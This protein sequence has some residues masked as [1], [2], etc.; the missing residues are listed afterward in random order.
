MNPS[1]EELDLKTPW[2]LGRARGLK[3][4]DIPLV[5]QI[6]GRATVFDGPGEKVPGV[7]RGMSKRDASGEMESEK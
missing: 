7:G 2:K 5:E 6:S 3:V 4:K 1:L